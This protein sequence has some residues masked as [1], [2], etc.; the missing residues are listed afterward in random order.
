MLEFIIIFTYFLRSALKVTERVQWDTVRG[1][2][3]KES[4]YSGLVT[5]SNEREDSITRRKEKKHGQ[6]LVTLQPN[7]D[8]SF[9]SGHLKM[10][11]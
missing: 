3:R 8:K 11:M 6:T 10:V 7:Y 1:K 4:V 5:I 2:G 9:S